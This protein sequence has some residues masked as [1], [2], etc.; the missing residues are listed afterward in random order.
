MIMLL[1]VTIKV[2][3]LALTALAAT[4]LLRRRSAAVRHFVLA[5]MFFCSLS[6]PA[7]ERVMPSWP[8]PLPSLWSTAPARSSL[9]LVSTPP[10]TSARTVPVAAG[11]SSY[12]GAFSA[13]TWL[14]SIWI[15][16][17]VIGCGVL[18]V[19]FL[20]LRTLA[21]ASLPVTCG[22]WRELADEISRLYGVGRP[23]R[24]LRS[25]HPTMLATWG[26]VTPTIVLPAGAED[27]PTD[28]VHAV[29]CHELAHIRR[30][31]WAVALAANVLR[32]AYWFNP[33]LW[34]A[35]RRLRH[36][37]ERAC[38]DLVLASGVSGAEY[39]THLLAVARQSVTHRHPWSP[40][41]AVA[42]HSMLEGRV[43]AMLSTRVNREP[44]T[45]G[46]CATT[47]AALVALTVSIGI[48]TVSGETNRPVRTDVRL[49]PPGVLPVIP[50]EEARRS[51]EPRV[52]AGATPAVQAQPVAGTI[53]GVLYDPF[54]GL[55]P[56]VAVRLTQIGS[57]STQSG[58]SD[59]GGAFVFRG[60]ATGDYELI[61]ELPGF[62]TVKNVVRAESG[63]TAR[64]HIT[65]PIG[66][67]EETIHATCSNSN[68]VPSPTAPAGS[69]SPGPAQRQA[70]AVQRGAEPKV[71]ASTFTGGIGGQIK[72]PTKLRH[73][74]P[75]C[76]STAAPVSTVVR[77][78]GRIGIDG[79]LTDVHDVSADAQAAYVAS[80]LEAARQWVFTPTLLNG[81]PIEANISMT[82]SYSSSN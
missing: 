59:R 18:L 22:A 2:A 74:N 13:T 6:V 39:A 82:F 57:G 55:L 12:E 71:P 60:L 11:T 28:R 72:A 41:I 50:A 27:W 20:R 78:A 45:V 68:R 43:R 49:T 17:T 10:A 1:S 79:L 54:G 9:R 56:G 47:V 40:A 3:V 24:I 4:A 21:A 35:C 33:L 19:G 32:A 16:G 65:L 76:P 58:I 52:N 29:L 77:L 63:Q 34:V 53:E 26:L 80:A 66:T 73:V 48:V 23:V 61:T 36:E 64:R 75:I 51:P 69:P 67:I 37:G 15:G 81:A 30:G 62:I 31:D 25:Q 8:V 70:V 42:H 14:M 7:V 5:T 38:D 46:A 44:L